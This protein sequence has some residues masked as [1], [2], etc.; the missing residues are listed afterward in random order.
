[1]SVQ[2]YDPTPLA[3]NAFLTRTTVGALTLSFL[4]VSPTFNA[5]SSPSMSDSSNIR[6]RV[7]SLTERLFEQASFSSSSRASIL[8]CSLI[9]AGIVYS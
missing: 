2:S 9:A 5:P 7:F 6:A 3:S 8:R 1:M 4:H